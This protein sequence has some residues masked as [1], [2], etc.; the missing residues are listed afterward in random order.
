MELI[1][2]PYAGGSSR[3]YSQLFSRL[4][5]HIHA[6]CMEYPGH[7]IKSHEPLLYEIE[8]IATQL[9]HEL[10]CT[11]TFHSDYVFYGHSMGAL[12][13]YLVARIAAEHG[14]R[15]PCH[16]IVSGKSSPTLPFTGRKHLLDSEDFWQSLSAMGGIP[17]ELMHDQQLKCYF[18]QILRAD[19]TA[20]ETWQWQPARPLQCPVTVWYGDHEN[21]SFETA[22][23]WRQVTTK[24]VNIQSFPG[25]HFFIFDHS[26]LLCAVI[27]QLLA[28]VPVQHAC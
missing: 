26:P 2:F 22:S 10:E 28:P 15:P 14:Y 5:Q 13:S 20:A 23:A 16:L 24:S 21:V 6:R 12:V 9:F 1:C 18:E 7:G 19:F 8:T 25:N 3:A 17:D 27:N 4:N 11:N